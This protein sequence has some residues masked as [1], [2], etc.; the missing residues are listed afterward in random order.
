MRPGPVLHYLQLLQLSWV[1]LGIMAHSHRPKEI[2]E[3]IANSTKHSFTMLHIENSHQNCGSLEPPFVIPQFNGS[4]LA[5]LLHCG[6]APGSSCNFSA[7]WPSQ[8]WQT[9][10]VPISHHLP[11]YVPTVFCWFFPREIGAQLIWNFAVHWSGGGKL[12]SLWG[13][14]WPSQRGEI[15]ND[16]QLLKLETPSTLL[17]PQGWLKSGLQNKKQ[18][19]QL[20]TT[21]FWSILELLFFLLPPGGKS[22]EQC[23]FSLPVN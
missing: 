13:K 11:Q 22:L 15:Q 16:A 12:S 18:P 6:V 1:L 4:P 7:R 14:A 2:Q 20:W 19:G 10:Y 8:N 17:G 23:F 5:Q 21:V 9:G 3:R